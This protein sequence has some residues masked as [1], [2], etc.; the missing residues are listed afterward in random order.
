MYFAHKGSRIYYHLFSL[1]RSFKHFME[2]TSQCI[3]CQVKFIYLTHLH[4]LHNQQPFQLGFLPNWQW[5]L[6]FVERFASYQK[7]CGYF[8]TSAANKLLLTMWIWFLIQSFHSLLLTF[9]EGI[10]VIKNFSCKITLISVL[11]PFWTNIKITFTHTHGAM[12]KSD[13]TI[14]SYSCIFFNLLLFGSNYKT[15]MLERE[16]LNSLCK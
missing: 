15:L 9:W 6:S 14:N 3:Y 8:A 16:S 12:I 4:I 5:H 2:I 1:L 13:Y 11:F 10:W 7:V